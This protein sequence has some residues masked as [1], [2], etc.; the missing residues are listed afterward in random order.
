MIGQPISHF[1][2]WRSSVGGGNGRVVRSPK[3]SKL[4]RHVALK[5]LPE[6]LK[7][8]PAARERFQRNVVS[9]LRRRR[10]ARAKT[11]KPTQTGSAS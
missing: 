7:D 3:T 4:G 11:E 1:A 10:I 6:G 8:D 9:E 5:F 2:S